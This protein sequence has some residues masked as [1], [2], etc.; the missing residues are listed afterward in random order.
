MNNRIRAFTLVE[1]IVVIGIL[2]IL[3]TILMP[4]VH[5]V[6]SLAQEKNCNANLATIGKAIQAY[7]DKYDDFLPTNDDTDW[8]GPT[9]EEEEI[10]FLPGR[11]STKRWWCN[12][13]YPLG[14]RMQ[15]L[16]RC[17]SDSIHFN[18]GEAVQCSYG[19]NETL[20]DPNSSGGDGLETSM[21]INKPL[22]TFLV[23]H[24]SPESLHGGPIYP[25]INEQLVDEGAK[26]PTGHF[27][28]WD[29]VAEERLG[30]AGFLMAGMNVKVFTFGQV[31]TLKDKNDKL[32]LFH[33]N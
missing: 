30:R 22:D 23:G 12:K 32:K 13:I 2:T 26:W 24:C 16:Y 11:N 25:G 5:R 6:L 21:Q 10:N 1:L 18:P 33:K 31:K 4:T 3:A 29:G 28:A 8:G 9:D 17:P 27:P 15:K 20:T 14:H 19:F 7:Y